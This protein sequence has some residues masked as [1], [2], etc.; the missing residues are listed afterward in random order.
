MRTTGQSAG[1]RAWWTAIAIVTGIACAF[2]LGYALVTLVSRPL[3][4]SEGN[5]LFDASRIR[6]GLPLY[7]DPLEGARDYGPVPSRYFVLYTPFWAVLL[8]AVPASLAAVCARLV[9][10]ASWLGVLAWIVATAPRERRGA[11][12][13]GAAFVV[14][15]YPIMLFATAGRPDSLAVALAGIALLRSA[16]RGRVGALEGAL[17]ALAPFFKP[18]VF[19]A[20]AGAIAAELLGRKGRGAP[21]L[22]GAASCALACSGIL[23]AASGGVWLRHLLDSSWMPFSAAVWESQAASRF[24]FFAAPLAFCAWCA[25]K[26]GSRV[27][28]WAL[29]ASLAWTV[30]S[31][32]KIGSATNYWMEP[33]MTGV[34]VLATSPVP[35]LPRWLRAAAGPLALAQVVWT[36]M[37]AIRSSVGAVRLAPRK[38]AALA[39][40]RSTCGAAATDVVM[41][42]EGG[43]EVM[44]D[45]RLL[46]QPL[47][48]TQLLRR[49]R[50]P[51]RLWLDDVSRPEVRCLVMQSDW[52]ERDGDPDGPEDLFPACLRAPLRARFVLARDGDGV[53]VYRRR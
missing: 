17:F 13:A 2:T 35:R 24:P 1:A 4:G 18:N 11:A 31:I 48:F 25:A 28:L 27:A 45:G 37:A 40:A 23:T 38:A 5:F 47:V 14:G 39:T 20:G 16:R 6:Q 34:V 12:L 19:A 10:T 7:V 53:W 41:A 44:L 21:A 9:S 43:I 8:A 46:E 52:L 33:C 22:V 3:D 49:G 32:A 36:G 15:V 50:F 29:A 42:D 26:A 51:E 30:W